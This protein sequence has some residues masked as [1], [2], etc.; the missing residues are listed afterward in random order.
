[1][2]RRIL[3]GLFAAA[4]LM[5]SV[6]CWHRRGLCRDRDTCSDRYYAPTA[7]CDR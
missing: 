5:P 1:M 7:D 4:V 6:G 3:L 2:T